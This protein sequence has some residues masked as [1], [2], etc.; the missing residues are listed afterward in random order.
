MSIQIIKGEK[1][2]RLTVIGEAPK[3]RG[4][5]RA[6][7]CKCECENLAII[8]NS[9]LMSGHNKSCGCFLDEERKQFIE[10]A[11]KKIE[12]IE[13][14]CQYPELGNCWVCTSHSTDIDGYIQYRWDGKRNH[15]SR[16]IWEQYF[17]EIPPKMQICHKCDN[18]KCINPEH[19]FLGTARDNAIDK[20]NKGR[21]PTGESHWK[22][23]LTQK[24]VLEI[25][26]S[27]DRKIDISK[28][29]KISTTTIYNIKNRRTWRGVLY[30]KR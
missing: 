11:S 26:N 6:S 20:A 5:H 30:D 16:F 27:C 2:G 1:Y 18:P 9:G 12:W 22:T 28:E 8:R 24:Q 19:L 10:N 13:E 25:L 29:Y 4:G 21:A 15:M 17:G 7:L 23:K 14:P 3:M